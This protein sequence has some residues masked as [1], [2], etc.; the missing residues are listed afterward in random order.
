MRGADEIKGG[1]GADRSYGQRGN[2]TIDDAHGQDA[3]AISG[4]RGADHIFA[5]YQDTV[6][7]GAGDDV[8]EFVYPGTA[9]ISCGPGDDTVVFNQPHP[10][11]TLFDCE[12][13]SIKSAG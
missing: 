13:V 5:N 4:G 11:V 10:D 1:P 2:D 12:N 6:L 3:D 8:I 9:K 7:A